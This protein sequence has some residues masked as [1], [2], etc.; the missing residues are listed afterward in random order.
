MPESIVDSA[1]ITSVF[2]KVNGSEIGDEM[3]A[4]LLGVEIDSHLLMPDMLRLSFI[5][6]T[7]AENT[8]H[9]A[10]PLIDGDVFPLGA[11]VEVEVGSQ[12]NPRSTTTIFEGEITA[13]EPQFNESM[14]ARIEVQAY[15][16]SWRAFRESKTKVW[17][18]VT[19]SD[20]AQQV[21][22]GTGLSTEVES[23]SEVYPHIYQDNQSDLAFL[24]ERAWRIGFETFVS[25]GKLVFRKPDPTGS[26]IDL[27][28]GTTLVSF[29]P[30]LT[31]AEQV[32]KVTVKGWDVKKKEPITG[33]VTS[34]KTSPQINV[35]GWGGAVAMSKVSAATLNVVDVPVQSQADADSVAKGRL[36]ELNGAFIEAEGVAFGVPQLKAGMLVNL[37]KLGSKFSGKYKVTQVTHVYTQEMHFKTHFAVTGIRSG[38]TAERLGL[39]DP[40]QRWYGVYP[41]I[42]TD[43][44]PPDDWGM[45]K[46]K[47]PWLDDSQDSYW[48]RNVAPGGGVGR[49]FYNLPEVN[50]E[51]LVVFEQGDINRPYILGGLWN[52]KDKPPEPLGNVAKNGNVETRVW[53]SRIGHAITM[54]DESGKEKVEIVTNKGHIVTLDDGNQKMELKTTGGLTITLDDA[55]KN[56]TIV[57]TKDII[58]DATG[59]INMKAKQD[60]TIEAM[61]N[62]NLKATAN[63][64][65]KAT[66]NL[67]AEG[68]MASMKGNANV[69][70]QGGALA[71]VKAA[72]VKIN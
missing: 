69:T 55:S 58:V 3:V 67:A 7:N 59:N 46:V 60:V 35:G 47:Y 9:K 27:E 70:V 15:D 52:G 29:R 42:V 61:S 30:R 66:G 41:A 17:K 34:S 31:L 10:F 40:R 43:N 12:D 65:L 18:E 2:I 13:V 45:V 49:G 1:L 19:D 64:N 16:K 57:G 53:K 11:K 39:R 32:D 20:I 6:A 51:V 62:L 68:T 25:N 23:T 5:D 14:E 54:V 22:A 44:E 50:D 63:L 37:T 71:E 38:T 36:D 56:I 21:A 33:Q 28:W 72:L 26:A 48:A 4:Y 8:F 24:L